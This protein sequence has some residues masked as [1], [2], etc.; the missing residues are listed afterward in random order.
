MEK[1]IENVIDNIIAD[2][3]S[4]II[5]EGLFSDDEELTVDKEELKR[6]LITYILNVINECKKVQ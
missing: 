6:R 4:V 2:T 5:L 3:T 1:E